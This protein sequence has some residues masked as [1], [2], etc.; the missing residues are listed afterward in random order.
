MAKKTEAV[1]ATAPPMEQRHSTQAAMRFISYFE[2]LVRENQELRNINRQNR[3]G[4]TTA[5]GPTEDAAENEIPPDTPSSGDLSHNP[6]LQEKPWF[7]SVRSSNIPILIG[8]VADAAFAT[9]FRQLLTN[10]ALHHTLR[11]SYP[12][13]R[14]IMALIQA[15]CLFPRPTN[16]R[17]LVRVALKSLDGYFH[18]LRN[19]RVWE[20]LEQSLQALHTVDSISQC[21]LM[22][23]FAL[24]ELYSSSCRAQETATPGLAFFSHASKAHGLLQERPSVDTIEVSLLLCLYTLCINRRHSAYFLASSAVRHCLVMGL[25]FDLPEAQLDDPETKEHL[26]RLWWTAYI[27]DH[28]SASVS[29]Q[30]V[31]VSDDEIFVH[32]PSDTRVT[33]IRH[34]DFQHTELLI[35]RIQLAKATKCMIKSVYGRTQEA[36]P[37]L[38]RVQHA[39]RDLKQWLQRLPN[40]MKID[41]ESSH[42]KPAAVQS[43]HLAFNQ[44]VI[45]ATRPV[46]LHMLRMQKESKG[47]TP[48]TADRMISNN[49]QV[50][51]DACIRCARHSYATVIESWVEGSFRTFDYFNTRYLFSAATILAI[52]SLMGDSESSAD[53]ESFDFA[54]QLL[55]KLR[56][57]GSFSATEF[58]RHIEAMREDIHGYLSTELSSLDNEVAVGVLAAP[59]VSSL[60]DN[61]VQF[62]QFMTSGMALAEPSL[63][64]FLQSEQSLPHVDF[65]LDNAHS[66]CLYWPSYDSV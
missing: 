27:M 46:L 47:D 51:G 30:I 61:T 25:H 53:R 12:E 41:S 28:I 57:S 62:T 29:S 42:S 43:L 21:K 59:E 45:V 23:L 58:C 49:V 15:E 9:R 26:N 6:V 60:P 22:A 56:D 10:Q 16:A 35:S 31:S 33:D 2:N 32:L 18:I 52:S 7:L 17:F 36:E 37:F 44:C 19:S 64:A 38:Q 39:L 24:G 40:D 3:M 1:G 63:E 11:V 66:G 4:G 13:N 55:E 48:A 34:T 65:L 54:G 8:E 20:L 14:Q 5:Q 50:L